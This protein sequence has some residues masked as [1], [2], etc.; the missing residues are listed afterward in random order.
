MDWS[1]VKNILIIAYLI[2]DI[3]L[4]YRI[5]NDPVRLQSRFTM[6]SAEEIRELE[7]RLDAVGVTLRASLPARV[8]ALRFLVL[9]QGFKPDARLAANL[10]G[11][12][13]A[14]LETEQGGDRI[15]E[16]DHSPSASQGLSLS[17]GRG[18]DY[19]PRPKE[20]SLGYWHGDERVVVYENGV[21]VYLRT[22]HL[23]GEGTSAWEGTA[24]T[25]LRL[26]PGLDEEVVTEAVSSFLRGRRILPAGARF[27]G[28]TYD[29]RTGRYVV[30]YYQ[31]Y[32]GFCIFGG[33]VTFSVGPS[34]RHEV[35]GRPAGD[36]ESSG[37]VPPTKRGYDRRG[38]E[39]SNTRPEVEAALIAWYDP[40][41]YRG[42]LRPVI[43]P[44]E[45]VASAVTFLEKSGEHA[46]GLSI[47]SVTL[48]YYTEAYNAVE[49]ECPPVWRV[50]FSRGSE[51]GSLFVNAY[52]SEIEGLNPIF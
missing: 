8:P 5:V 25:A 36:L 30:R 52:T 17:P 11:V 23:K 35:Y 46:E 41:G 2:L 47:D 1:R 32:D 51:Q 48:G 3:A 33:Q 39:E 24:D 7:D 6:V 31:E 37:G 10:L 34:P 27:D 14:D 44:T 40:R 28:I 9:R 49:W 13:P 21:T 19:T 16:R 50:K 45:A 29:E 20:G 18:A 12:H 42:R 4:G 26:E 22:A 38:G 15:G 43:P